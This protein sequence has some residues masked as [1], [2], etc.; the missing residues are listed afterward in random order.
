M[1]GFPATA[2]EF[3]V[4]MIDLQSI[5]GIEVYAGMASVPAVFTAPRDL[6]RCGVIAVWSRPS[7]PKRSELRPREPE[8]LE[9]YTAD[10]V[11][12]VARPDSASASPVY[13]DSLFRGGIAGK[14][15]VEF[16]V[17]TLGAVEPESIEVLAS[18]DSL[19]TEAVRDALIRAHFVPARRKGRGVRQIVQYP[20]VFSPTLA[21]HP[22]G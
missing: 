5:E 19:F 9:A 1:D 20:F 15:V 2:G 6:D 8:V 16:V 4:D 22:E 3:D 13:P 11:D 21:Q 17:D 12:V 14:V 10:D 18:S 7:R